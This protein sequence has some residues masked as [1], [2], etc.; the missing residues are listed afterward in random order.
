MDCG[1]TMVRDQVAR[2]DARCCA[3]GRRPIWHQLLQRRRFHA[4]ERIRARLVW[5][6][7][8]GVAFQGRQVY[9]KVGPELG[10]SAFSLGY[11]ATTKLRLVATTGPECSTQFSS[12]PDRSRP[13][14]LSDLLVSL[15]ATAE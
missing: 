13:W 7:A 1:G 4:T 11:D 8:A 10:D 3:Y 14:F 15:A 5:R 2:R 9:A 12:F 6:R